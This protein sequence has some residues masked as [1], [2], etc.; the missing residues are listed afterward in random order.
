MEQKF[1]LSLVRELRGS[2]ITVLIAIILL[3]QADCR[4][5]TAQALKDVTGYSDN[6]VTDSLRALE[7][8]T[9]QIITRVTG[10]WIL[11]TAEQMILPIQ[12]RN[13]SDFHPVV[14]DVV[15]IEGERVYSQQQ[16]Q[17]RNI[18]DSLAAAGIYE[19]MASRLARLKWV[20]A[21]YIE[22]HVE[23]ISHETWDNPTGMLIHRIKN[24]HP[25][26]ARRSEVA[27]TVDRFIRR[28]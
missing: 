5:I 26:P 11:T 16:P 10:G 2:P 25:V 22:G 17:N 24:N 12:N 3:D 8:P 28:R 20:T 19:P 4:P 7:H 14:N 9:R 6:T 18:S 23:A 13:I 15:V 27:L 21:E 1:T